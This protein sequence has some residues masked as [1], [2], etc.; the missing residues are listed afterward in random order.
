MLHG[1]VLNPVPR[2]F[3]AGELRTVEFA[4]MRLNPWIWLTGLLGLIVCI[5]RADL[6]SRL[7]VCVL[8]ICAAGQFLAYPRIMGWSWAARFPLIVPHELQWTFQLA[9]AVCVGIG[10]D[11]LIGRVLG[12]RSLAPHRGKLALPALLVALLL[13]GAWGLPGVNRNLRRFVHVYGRNFPGA[14]AWIRAN[15]HIEDVFACEPIWAFAWLNADTGRKVWLTE[16]GHSNPRVDWKGRKRVLDEMAAAPTPEAFWRIL[17]EHDVGYCVPSPGWMPR[18]LADPALR[19]EA[20]PAYLEL[21]YGG[22]PDQAAILRVRPAR[23]DA[24]APQRE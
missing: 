21:V 10:I 11:A 8:G 17:R 24:T 2:E 9:W 16:P 20:V 19:R 15:T 23:C 18:V 22:G 6:A 7:V 1:P 14:T 5:R 4:L 12:W 13:T 3:I